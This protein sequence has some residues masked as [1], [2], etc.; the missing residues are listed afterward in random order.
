MDVYSRIIFSLIRMTGQGGI[1]EYYKKKFYL[2]QMSGSPV[3][4]KIK[5]KSGVAVKAKEA[6]FCRYKHW[7]HSQ[8]IGYHI[9]WTMIKE[10]KT[11]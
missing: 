11:D 3:A 7:I 5:K 2:K 1:Y 4:C 10:S 8:A 6:D 9:G